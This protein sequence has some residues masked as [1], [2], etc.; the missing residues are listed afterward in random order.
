VKLVEAAL[1]VFEREPGPL[2]ILKFANCGFE[3]LLAQAAPVLVL[4][5]ITG[6][7]VDE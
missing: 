5:V 3:T 1:L 6:V 7:I 2:R 4:Q